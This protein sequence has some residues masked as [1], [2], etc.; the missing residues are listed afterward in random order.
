MSRHHRPW[1]GVHH[2]SPSPDGRMRRAV[3]RVV[4]VVYDA[5]RLSV[6]AGATLDARRASYREAGGPSFGPHCA[7]VA[8]LTV[9]TFVPNLP[10]SV[11]SVVLSWLS[12]KMA[13][14]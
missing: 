5:E 7:L 2:G 14:P 4:A 9:L 1:L 12:T 8:Q 10:Y 3:G 13:M 6:A 11:A